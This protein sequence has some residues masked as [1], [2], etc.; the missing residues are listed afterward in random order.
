MKSRRAFQ[1]LNAEL[2]T[3][4]G[5]LQDQ[6]DDDM[7]GIL[8]SRLTQEGYEKVSAADRIMD[9][10]KGDYEF[11]F[12]KHEAYRRESIVHPN[13]KLEGVDPRGKFSKG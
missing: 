5:A 3:F 9:D 11:T 1:Y 12:K 2:E 10:N 7:V 8:N 4:D 13:D 6:D